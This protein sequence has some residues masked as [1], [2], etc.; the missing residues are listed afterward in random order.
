LRPPSHELLGVLARDPQTKASLVATTKLSTRRIPFLESYRIAGELLYPAGAFIEGMRA[1]AAT[2]LGSESVELRDVAIERPLR[3]EKDA[4][5]ELRTVVDENER[6]I[7]IFSSGDG[8]AS[9]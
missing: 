7:T 5:I 6:K 4:S 2:V 3:L 8:G 9:W 1:A